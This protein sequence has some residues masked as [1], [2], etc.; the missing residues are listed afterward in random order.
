M[1]YAV[2]IQSMYS[3]ACCVRVCKCYECFIDFGMQICIHTPT[4]KY[5]YSQRTNNHVCIYPK[6]LY[7][8]DSIHITHTYTNINCISCS[9]AEE[10]W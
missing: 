6:L 4:V 3:G 10:R 5:I 9:V 8:Q 2:G 7:T 1:V